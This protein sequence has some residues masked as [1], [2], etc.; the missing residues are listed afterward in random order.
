MLRRFPLL[1][2]AAIVL[3]GTACDEPTRP[4]TTSGQILRDIVA[5]EPGTLPARANTSR[6]GT[7]RLPAAS[8]SVAASISGG[9][10]PLYSET[11]KLRLSVDGIG[12]NDP[13]GVVQVEKVAGATVRRAFL[14]AATTPGQRV[15]LAGDVK[16]DGVGFGWDAAVTSTIGSSNH[17]A[18]VTTLVKP[19]IDA[20][21]AGRVNFTITEV[22]TFQI[23]GEILAVVFDDP[24]QATDNTVVLFFG[25]QN[26]A[27]DQF[28]VSLANP[29]NL[30]DP[31][32]ALNMGLGISFGFQPG[33]QFSTVDVNGSRLSSSAGGQDDGT[34]LSVGNGAL[35]TVGGLDDATSNPPP[36]ASAST[37]RTDDEL[38]DLKPFVANA[39]TSITVATR[40]PSNDDN[41]FFASF[42]LTVEASVIVNP[43]ANLPPVANPGGPY[44]GAEGSAISFNGTGSSD[45]DGDA[46]T[47]AWDF[48]NDGIPDATT[49]TASH[50]YADNGLYTAKLTVNDGKGGSDSK[51]VTVT[52]SNV[53]PSLG[54]LNVPA[55]PLALQ[56]GGT[57]VTI[58]ASFTDPGTLD[59]HT[60]ALSCDGGAAGAVS[61]SAVNGAGI[62]SGACTFSGAGVY[63][64]SMTVSDDDGGSDTRTATAYIVIYD[65]SAGF[66]TGGGWIDS[67]VGAYPEGASL[68]GKA[69]FGF[70]SK[71]QKGAITPTG[72]TEFQFHAASLDFHSDSY[73]WLV[74][75]GARAQYKG[76]GSIQGRAGTYGF[77]V[78]AIDGQLT[79][80][81]GVDK[82]RIKIWDTATSAIIYDNQIGQLE[83]SGAAT[84]LGGGSIVV[85]SK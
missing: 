24:A 51:P 13:S 10:S 1:S 40:N 41:I 32:L 7:P 23:D 22:G 74:I 83:D 44:A 42:F 59:T 29:V 48:E 9:L 21:P 53:A 3:V 65:P 15:L 4:T 37:P 12:T 64:V 11:G 68:T 77:L 76:L 73:Q 67:P 55:A 14:A 6:I 61:A 85:H 26:V 17:W 38:Y 69:T 75:A 71:Y 27:G 63:T 78:T 80:G 70:V 43:P 49:A 82:F 79:G 81:G 31:S 2:A 62:A 35:L 34:G 47:Y 16:I 5:S 20:A 50:T 28:V 8:A 25:A 46:L 56:A 57:P 45:P 19:K 30:S 39:A 58:S 60:G 33:G 36:L 66:V 54:A 18:D 84:T 52:V 72:N